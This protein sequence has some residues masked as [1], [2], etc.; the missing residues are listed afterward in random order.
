M[1]PNDATYHISLAQAYRQMGLTEEMKQEY[2]IYERLQREAHERSEHQ[3]EKH[4][5]S[6]DQHSKEQ[7]LPQLQ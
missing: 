1:D 7:P 2:S 3:A 6:A 5:E 4:F